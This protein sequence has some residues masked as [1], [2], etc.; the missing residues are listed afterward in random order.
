MS[1]VPLRLRLTAAFALAMAVLLASAGFLLY[2]RLQV[3]LD[4]T[5]DQ[6]LRAR[7]A[8]VAALV[9]QADTGLSDSQFRPEFAQVLDPRGRVFD[10]TPGLAR[11]LLGGNELVQARRGPLLAGSTLGSE[12]VRLFA[13]PVAA[14]GKRLVVVVGSPLETRDDALTAL[15]TELLIGGPVGLV[16]ASVIGYLLAAAALRPV[17]RMRARAA[18]I[19]GA[20]PSERL[21]VPPS[22]DEVARLGETLNAMLGRLEAA[23]ERERSFVADAS[24]ELRMPLAHL[25]AEIELALESPRGRDELEGALRSVASEADR[26]SQLAEDLLLLARVDE[27]KLPIRPEEADLKE[28]LDN[29]VLRFQRRARDA[30]RTI[31]T[32]GSGRARVD[33]VR[34]EQALANLIENALRHGAGTVLVSA[35]EDGGTVELHVTDEGQGFEPDFAMRAF[36]R[37]TRADRS[38][39]DGGLGLGL[40]IVRAIA[41]AHG[42]SAALAPAAGGGADASIRF[43]ARSSRSS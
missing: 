13:R 16:V 28:L 17:E 7:A 21:P 34:V 37:Y 14:Q 25:Q 40:A 36:E 22:N 38:R 15:R 41:E 23:L 10:A 9:T 39:G 29:V 31:E 11:P 8:D 26:L 27:G 5:L 1:H 12:R 43:P 3:S 18:A 20:P 30:G 19:S 32:A 4:R 6:G 35:R 24:H 2:D 33:R 42:G